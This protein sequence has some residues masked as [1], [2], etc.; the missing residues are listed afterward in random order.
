MSIITYPLDNITYNAKDAETYL[1]TRTS[2]VF[3]AEDCF[4]ATA[5]GSDRT[6]TISKGLAWIKNDDYRGKSICSTG[7]TKIDIPLASGTLSRIDRIVLRF[8]TNY[9]A[10]MIV[11]KQGTASPAPTPPPIEQT[12]ALYELGLCEVRVEAGSVFVAQKD[13]TSTLL[14]EQ[15]CGVMS[16]GVKGIPT[17][18]LFD[19]FSQDFN[20]WFEGIKSQLSGD[21][22]TNLQNQINEVEQTLESYNTKFLSADLKGAN[23]GVATLDN[24]GKV[25]QSQLP[26]M[27]YIPTS[28]K[29]AANGVASLGGDGKVPTS[30][31]PIGKANGVAGLGVDGKIAKVNLPEQ[32]LY[33][34][35]F[36]PM[37]FTEGG[38]VYDVT[39]SSKKWF[40]KISNLRYSIL[41]RKS[42]AEMFPDVETSEEFYEKEATC[43]RLYEL[44]EKLMPY[45]VTD[46]AFPAAG[47]L[48]VTQTANII[49]I[50][51]QASRIVLLTDATIGTADGKQVSFFNLAHIADDDTKNIKAFEISC[52]KIR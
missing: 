10:S 40:Q 5:T 8:D 19:K 4:K 37:C 14:N 31:L 7:D 52:Y 50:H 42:M 51:R 28:Q 45:N 39:S 23:D 9:N 2:G 27:D 17:Q 32:P 29:A 36:M 46:Y 21:V 16:D 11:L 20:D 6:V 15:V 43:G 33:L 35:T 25:P 41:S 1:C 38:Q 26:S 30:Q 47:S 44:T 49:A 18:Q 12:P 13:I 34:Y 24:S 48:Q 22:A 3:S